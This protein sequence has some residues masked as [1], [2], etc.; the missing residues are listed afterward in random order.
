MTKQTILSISD[1]KKV[2]DTIAVEILGYSISGDLYIKDNEFPIIRREFNPLTNFNDAFM[3]VTAITQNT[4]TTY[5]MNKCGFGHECMFDNER[6]QKIGRVS[7][8]T[9]QMAVCLSGLTYLGIQTDYVE[10][11][12]QELNLGLKKER[13]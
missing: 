12:I 6:K 3:I 7:A 4:D 9:P 13:M 1:E 2:N 10:P 8:W 5:T 11:T